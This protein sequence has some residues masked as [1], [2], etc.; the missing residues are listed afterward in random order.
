[1]EFKRK[2]F[3]YMIKEW[4][5]LQSGLGFEA[6]FLSLVNYVTMSKLNPCPL[7]LKR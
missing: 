2:L 5:I 4:D 3:C 1:M 7:Y 6:L